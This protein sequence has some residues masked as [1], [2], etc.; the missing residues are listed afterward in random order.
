[1]TGPALHV[2]APDPD[3]V[4]DAD[5]LK[6]LLRFGAL[7]YPQDW[8]WRTAKALFDRGVIQA[9]GGLRDLIEA[10]HGND[11]QEV[12]E[13]L[14]RAEIERMGRQMSEAQQALTQVLDAEDAYDQPQMQRVFDD[15]RFPTRLGVPQVTLRLAREEDGRLVPW[16]GE[17]SLGWQ[18]SEVLVSAARY[19][20]LQGVDQ[21]RPRSQ[22]CVRV[23]RIGCRRG[24]SWHQWE[25]AA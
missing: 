17:G 10:V 22:P 7:V 19:W 11:P 14:R 5:W 24:Y 13:A 25:R 2:L 9:P 1:M 4:E 8:Q 3:Q 21:D 12:P 16:A 23:G 15:D 6:R 18:S 20:K